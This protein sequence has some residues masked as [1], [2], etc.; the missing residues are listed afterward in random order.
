M[1]IIQWGIIGCGDVTEHKSGPAFNK[2]ANSR[3]VAVMRRDGAKAADYARRHGVPKFYSDAQQ[4]INDPEVNAIYIATPPSSHAEYA[5][6]AIAAGK[7]VYVE[8]PMALN[9]TAALSMKVAAEDNNV[10]LVVAHYRQA[11]EFFVEIKSLLDSGRIG[12]V[13]EVSLLFE[14][15]PLDKIALQD[16]KKAWRV[17]PAISGGG[18]FHDMAPHQ[19]GLMCYFFGRVKSAAGHTDASSHVYAA[20]DRVEGNINFE[21][22]VIFNG[23]WN[24]NAS[25]ENDQCIIKGTEGIISFPIFGEHVLQIIDSKTAHIEF[26]IP[27]H[28]QQPMIAATVQYFLGEGPNPCDAAAG[29]EVMRLMELMTTD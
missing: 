2:V 16:A 11:Q 8:K 7:P 17:D 18:L 23:R 10:K 21:N 4:L 15:P 1:N 24:F 28:V 9:Y 25:V 14:R 12:T 19:L 3:L 26:T 29:C 5:L 27:Q 13:R 6:A 22:G 20:A